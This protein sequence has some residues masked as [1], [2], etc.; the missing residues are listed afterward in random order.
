MKLSRAISLGAVVAC[1]LLTLTAVP[2]HA[3][4]TLL[5]SPT[6]YVGRAVQTDA[7]GSRWYS[8]AIRLIFERFPCVNPLRLYQTE[9]QPYAMPDTIFRMSSALSFHVCVAFG[10][11]AGA[12][13][14]GSDAPTP[15]GQ[16]GESAGLP[17]DLAQ[18]RRE[19]GLVTNGN[20]DH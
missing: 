3:D 15:S 7:T 6:Q 19:L 20:F 17:R 2:A 16:A 5:Q 4:P 1:L 12:C 9:N 8:T 13:S 10:L 14:Q 11:L 18:I